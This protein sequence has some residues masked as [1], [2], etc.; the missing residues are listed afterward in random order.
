MSQHRKKREDSQEP[1]QGEDVNYALP[2]S[3]QRHKRTMPQ[4]QL[5]SANHVV[6]QFTGNIQCEFAMVAYSDFILIVLSFSFM[7][8]AH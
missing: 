8:Y 3:T 4:N 6:S 2:I 1:N 5:N 7:L